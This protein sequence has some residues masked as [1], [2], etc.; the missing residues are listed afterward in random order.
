ME[1]IK[2][3]KLKHS[4]SRQKKS[5]KM[6]YSQILSE[7]LED[8]IIYSHKTQGYLFHTLQE[9]TQFSDVDDD[10]LDE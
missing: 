6:W 9:L 10:S 3:K 7:K 4:K 8:Q 5:K 1:L 2:P